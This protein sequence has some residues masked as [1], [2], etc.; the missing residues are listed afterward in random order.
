MEIFIQDSQSDVEV[1]A[2]TAQELS[3]PDRADGARALLS[4]YITEHDGSVYDVVVLGLKNQVLYSLREN[5]VDTIFQQ[6][7]HNGQRISQ[8][9]LED[10]RLC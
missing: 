4:S 3:D 10:G 6:T 8:D 5:P 1:L 7:T 9:R 2:L